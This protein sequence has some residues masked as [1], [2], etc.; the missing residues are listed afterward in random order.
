MKKLL[1]IFAMVCLTH[2]LFAQRFYLGEPL[3]PNSTDFEFIGITSSTGVSNYRY[4]KQSTDLFFGRRI[5]D[6]VVG[7]RDGRIVLT[8]Y[9]LIPK[10]GD[11][12]VPR[13]LIELVQENIPFLFKEFDGAFGL[14][15]DNETITISRACNPITFNKDR[16][17]FMNSVKHSILERTK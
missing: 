5:D 8:I 7:V 16:I 11:V 6:I 15:I 4:K 9:N 10:P 2:I 14:H 12:G 17:M 3:R 13:D 1:M